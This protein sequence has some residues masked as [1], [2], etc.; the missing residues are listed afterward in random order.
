MPWGH[1]V[2]VRAFKHVGYYPKQLCSC[3]GGI[4]VPGPF[5]GQ[6]WCSWGGWGGGDYDEIVGWIGP[7][8]TN[9][10]IASFVANKNTQR[11]PKRQESQS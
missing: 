2:A 6:E 3:Q 1:P 8:G 10:P 5:S 9:F 11:K 4:V 7:V